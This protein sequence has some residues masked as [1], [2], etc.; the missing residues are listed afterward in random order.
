MYE[1][2]K[3]SIPELEG[4]SKELVDAHLG[5]YGG[6][7]KN[8]NAL[9]TLVEN[10]RVD[11][12]T[13]GTAIAEAVRRFAFEFDGMRMHEYYFEQWENKA[14]TL[15][16]TDTLAQAL[17]A[18]FGSF[19]AWEAQFRTVGMMRGV[20][21]A[22]LYFD[23]EQKKFINAWVGEHMDGHLV[24]LPVICA[25]DVWEHAYL[26]QFGTGGRATYIDAFFKNLNWSVMAKRFASLS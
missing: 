8:T 4:I 22:V 23:P 3:F 26:A 14:E 13:H 24:S 18:Q 11:A 7:V 10:L 15:A 21:W 25:L 6:Y 9:L 5:L 20:G 2:K 19:E 16:S 17:A 1:E 12:A